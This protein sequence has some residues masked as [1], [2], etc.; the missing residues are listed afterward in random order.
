MIVLA[1]SN[2]EDESGENLMDHVHMKQQAILEKLKQKRASSLANVKEQTEEK[3]AGEE[4]RVE[5]VKVEGTINLK[6]VEVNEEDNSLLRES[7][8]KP[9]EEELSEKL[10]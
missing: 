10:N 6:K 4:K 7:Q 8:V 3:V 2:G 9:R 5:D 1:E